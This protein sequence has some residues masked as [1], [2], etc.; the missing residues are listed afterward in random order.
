MEIALDC[1]AVCTGYVIGQVIYM[2]FARDKTIDWRA[3]PITIA[4]VLLL[5]II[6]NCVAGAETVIDMKI[7]GAIVVGCS[8]GQLISMKFL[9]R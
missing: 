3:L 9:G 2:K 8:C 5:R 1:F 4:L 7:F 6:I